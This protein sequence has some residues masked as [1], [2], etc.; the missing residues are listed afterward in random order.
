MIWAV[1][2]V[3][4]LAGAWW[5]VTLHYRIR[6]LENLT[7]EWG[8]PRAPAGAGKGRGGLRVVR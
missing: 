7:R 8:A 4:A 3:L 2:I 6:T 1:T 5:C